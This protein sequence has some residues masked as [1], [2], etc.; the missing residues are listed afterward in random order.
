MILFYPERLGVCLSKPCCVACLLI[1]DTW[2]LFGYNRKGIIL[3]YSRWE[4]KHSVARVHSHVGKLRMEASPC[5][6][7][8]RSFGTCSSFLFFVPTEILL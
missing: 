7:W 6:T 2:S 3:L 5:R 8:L 4:T 1:L